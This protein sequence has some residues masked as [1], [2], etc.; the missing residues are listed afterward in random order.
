MFFIKHNPLCQTNFLIPH[1]YIYTV[2]FRI[3]AF[4]GSGF[5]GSRFFRVQ[6]F[7]GPGFLESRFFK[8]Q[9]FSVQVQFF[10][11][12]AQGLGPGFRSS[13]IV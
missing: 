4:Q 2:F 11:V 10:R 9:F 13:L 7:R 6:V 8:T 5:S 12:W 1:L 3:H